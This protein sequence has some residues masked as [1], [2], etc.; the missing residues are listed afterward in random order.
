MRAALAAAALLVCCLNAVLGPTHAR[1]LLQQECN[2]TA[3]RWSYEGADC[4]T[5]L[6]DCE[7]AAAALSPPRPP[8]AERCMQAVTCAVAGG[9]L[10]ACLYS[11]P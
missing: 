2:V 3:A 7:Q 10:A 6:P 5:L 9:Y 4:P 1:L 11:D 8:A